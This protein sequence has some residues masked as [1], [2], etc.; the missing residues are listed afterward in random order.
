MG[1]LCAP[2][3][4]IGDDASLLSL[5]SVLLTDLHASQ[6]HAPLPSSAIS[7]LLPILRRVLAAEP[8]AEETHH[9][10]EMAFTLL[11]A[12]ST[13]QITL[14]TE[15]RRLQAQLLFTAMSRGERWHEEAA[16]AL[17]HVA[18]T[19]DSDNL[20]VSSPGALSQ[21]LLCIHSPIYEI[22][23]ITCFTPLHICLFASTS[24]AS[25]VRLSSCL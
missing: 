8:K 18:S 3:A 5:V 23:C 17:I 13:P 4:P 9:L 2:T 12:H 19:L 25:H 16:K 11:C 21:P 7:L 6:R 22:T 24:P 1:C 10:G 14:Q 15:E 20:E